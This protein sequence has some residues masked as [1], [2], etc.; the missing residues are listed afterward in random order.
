MMTKQFFVYDDVG[1]GGG[2]KGDSCSSS[3]CC[4]GD[5]PRGSITGI[6]SGDRF[7]C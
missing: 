5:D 1:G 6:F 3:P 4:M 7:C 2:G